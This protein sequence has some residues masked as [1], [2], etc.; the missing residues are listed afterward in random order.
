MLRVD[1]SHHH[2][3]IDKPRGFDVQSLE[4]ATSRAPAGEHVASCG[5]TT[6]TTTI[7]TNRAVPTFSCQRVPPYRQGRTG[8]G[9]KVGN[10]DRAPAATVP[11]GPL[12]LPPKNER[13]RGGKKK[14]EREEKRSSGESKS[15]RSQLTISY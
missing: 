12:P 14:K 1:H 10:P 6:A 15:S 9:L 2:H 4:D 8:Q 13:E 3:H 11:L 5:L 7:Q